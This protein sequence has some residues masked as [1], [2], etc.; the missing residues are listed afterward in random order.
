MSP[1]KP[2][3]SLYEQCFCMLVSHIKKYFD[4]K[5]KLYQLDKISVEKNFIVDLIDK[6][7]EKCSCEK[8]FIEDNIVESIR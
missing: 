2:V 6:L 3:K 8:K 1:R 4:E 5:I 7:N